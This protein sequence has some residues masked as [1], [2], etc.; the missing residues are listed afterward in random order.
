L[1][2][3]K[4]DAQVLLIG[5]QNDADWEVELIRVLTPVE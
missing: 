5:Q 2:D 1:K 4:A 3:I